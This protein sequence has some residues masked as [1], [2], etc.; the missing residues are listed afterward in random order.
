[1]EYTINQLAKLAGV[2]ARTLRYYDEIELLKPVRINSSGYRIYGAAQVDRLQQILFYKALNVPLDQVASLLKDPAFDAISALK[3]HHQALLMRREQLDQ[4]ILTVERTIQAKKGDL[5]MTDSDKFEG[6]KKQLLD[7][8]EQQYGQVVRGKYGEE[9]YEAS[10]K[11]FKH[12]TEQEYHQMNQ[13]GE[14]ILE[15]LTALLSDQ[16][17]F[18]PASKEAQAV[19]IKHQQWITMAWGKYSPEAHL[20]LVEMYTQD[21]QF[22]AYYD[23]SGEGATQLLKASVEYLL[24]A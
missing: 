10:Y 18:D 19:A 1:M 2:S 4:L 13:L 9:A 16:A 20:G 11:A 14:E 23:K 8:N 22:T 17:A 7:D 15:S 6:F 21:P 5:D 24:M 3:Q 12:M